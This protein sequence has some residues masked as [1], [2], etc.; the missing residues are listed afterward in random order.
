MALAG[1]TGVFVGF[2]S[3]SDRNLE[4]ARKKTPRCADYARRVALLHDN[5]IQVNGSFVL[6]FDHDGPD[7]FQRTAEWVEANRLECATFHIL[8]PYPGTPLYRQ[9]EAE[10]RL[11]HRD[12]DHYDT[13]HVV[14]RP[15]RMTVRQ[16]A[17]GYAWCYRRLFSHR[18]MWCRRPADW[19][20]VPAY[21]G[22]SYL[23][24]R[25]NWLWPILIRHRLTAR[26]WRPLVEFTRLRHLTF[27]AHLERKTRVEDSP[28]RLAASLTPAGV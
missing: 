7:V 19:R 16:L 10:G 4:D 14:F 12:W 27:R 20:A 2:E 8:T 21:L 6:G 25:A 22:M 26:V 5:G 28:T 13:A 24:K 9:M 15:K 3:L 1:C 23:Y 17:D 11:L 18:S